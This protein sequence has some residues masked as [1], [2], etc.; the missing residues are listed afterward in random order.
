MQANLKFYDFDTNKPSDCGQ[1]QEIEFSSAELDWPGVILEK[2]SSPH[3]YPNNVYTPY[4]Y[5]A[6]ALDQDLHWNAATQNGMTELKTSRGDV[7]PLRL[8]PQPGAGRDSRME[9]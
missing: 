4:F 6:L 9:H 3:F 1:V 5:F 2:G 8:L 7:P